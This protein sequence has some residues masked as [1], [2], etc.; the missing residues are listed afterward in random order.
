MSGKRL[1]Y[2]WLPVLALQI[3]ILGLSAQPNLSISTRIRHLDKVVHF[4]EYACLGAVFYRASRLTGA[5]R[6]RALALTIALVGSAGGADEILQRSVP[7]RVPSM[8]DWFADLSGTGFGSCLAALT[9]R[10]W[11]PL[12]ARPLSNHRVVR[13]FDRTDDTETMSG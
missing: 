1:L 4:M 12:L 10:F 2:A 6:G 7:G 8:T 9:E 3:L 13:T 5:P 11:S